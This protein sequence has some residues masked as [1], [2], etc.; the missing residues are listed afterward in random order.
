MRFRKASFF[1]CKV[2]CFLNS[3]LQFTCV[4]F[5]H[6]VISRRW[7]GITF[8]CACFLLCFY[9]SNPTLFIIWIQPFFGR[10]F[11]ST[12]LTLETEA[13][14]HV[15]DYIH[16]HAQSF[17]LS[18]KTQLH[19]LAYQWKVWLAPTPVKPCEYCFFSTLKSHSQ[20]NSK[21]FKVYLC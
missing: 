7:D 9:K 20:M 19:F 1:F 12:S 4:C 6:F 15:L 2:R 14:C 8:W 3:T 11:Y 21:W 17:A 18:T 16:W 5:S 13:V 10:E